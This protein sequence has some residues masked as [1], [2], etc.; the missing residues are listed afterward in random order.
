MR[1]HRNKTHSRMSVVIL[2]VLYNI[3]AFE[4][5]RETYFDKNMCVCTLGVEI[6][7]LMW[8]NSKILKEKYKK[9]QFT[10]KLNIVLRLCNY[11]TWKEK[12]FIYS[13]CLSRE[14]NIAGKAHVPYYS[15]ICFVTGCTTVYCVIS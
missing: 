2:T 14:L 4:S 5:V 10:Y 6:W 15:I 1:R 12:R 3:P 7:S 11:F 13:E 9:K 8:I